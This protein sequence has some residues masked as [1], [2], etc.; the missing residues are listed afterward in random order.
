MK[1]RLIG[2]T[3]EFDCGP[4]TVVNAIRFLFEREEVPPALIKG[5][6]TLLNDTFSHQGRHGEHGTS[7]A[8]MRFLGEWINGYSRGCCF[9]LRTELLEDSGALLLPGSALEDCLKSGG[10][11][12]IRCWSNEYEHY[13]LLTGLEQDGA[14]AFDPYDEDPDYE[15]D[16][17]GIRVIRDQPKKMNRIISREILNT[18]KIRDYALGAQPEVLTFRR[19]DRPR[20]AEAD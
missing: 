1:N 15:E 8:A 12:A 16:L 13:V 3:T 18:R 10:C 9:P 14:A 2:Q 17:P 19:T 4:T 6:W 20:T 7:R 5:I 11:A